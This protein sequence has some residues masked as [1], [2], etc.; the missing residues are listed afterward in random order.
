MV[1][2]P[3]ED[4]TKRAL[5]VMIELHKKRIWNDEKTVNVMADACLHHNPKIVIAACKFFL[6]L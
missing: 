1:Q 2:D 4:A 6:F 3:N 5:K